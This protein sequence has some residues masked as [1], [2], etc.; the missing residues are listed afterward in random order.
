MGVMVG[1]KRT[2]IGREYQ[3]TEVPNAAPA[4]CRHESGAKLIWDCSKNT[5]AQL[6]DY[7]SKLSQIWPLSCNFNEEIALR[8]LARLGYDVTRALLW[9]QRR[10]SYSL[11]QEL[12]DES[13]PLLTP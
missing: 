10:P 2:R 8:V 9:F 3:A 5:E 13:K 4:E 11:I 1:K 7:L 6:E 12:V